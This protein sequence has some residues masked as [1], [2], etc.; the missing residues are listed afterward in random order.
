VVQISEQYGFQFP[1]WIDYSYDN[2]ENDYTRFG[3]YLDSVESILNYSVE[4]LHDFY[5]KDKSILE[6][7]RN[8]FYTRDYCKIYDNVCKFINSQNW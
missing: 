8:I 4:S 2:I 5:L 7:N 6:H 3:K 1:H